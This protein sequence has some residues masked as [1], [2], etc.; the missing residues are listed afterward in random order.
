MAKKDKSAAVVTIHGAPRMTPKGRKEIA[1][2][3]RRQADSLV[4]HG[5]DYTET[6]FT[7]R[8]LYR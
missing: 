3:L 4:K 2:W 8:Y 6:R 5:K 7:A 1:A